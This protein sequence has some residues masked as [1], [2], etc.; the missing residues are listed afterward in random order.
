MIPLRILTL[1]VTAPG[2]PSVLVL[3]PIEDTPE[4]K[5]RIV[6]IWIGTQEATQLGIAIEHVR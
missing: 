4:G 5:S 1:I 6:P 3:E 2:Q